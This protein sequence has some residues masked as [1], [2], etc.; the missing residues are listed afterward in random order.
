MLG[1]LGEAG[2]LLP[3]SAGKALVFANTRRKC[4]Q[5][6]CS[7]HRAGVPCSSIHG[8]KD[9]RQR[10]EALAGLRSGRIKVLVA[11]DV[12]ARGLDIKGVGL[13]VNYDAA[14][15]TEDYVHRIGRT[16]RAGAT[17]Y[18]VTFLTNKDAHKARGMIEVMRRTKQDIPR[19]LLGIANSGWGSDRRERRDGGRGGGG[20]YGGGGGGGGGGYARGVGYAGGGGG[21]GG[22]GGGYSGGDANSIPVGG[23]YGARD[24]SRSPRGVAQDQQPVAKSGEAPGTRFWESHWQWNEPT[25]GSSA[26]PKA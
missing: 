7:I 17:G 4:E 26:A 5:L 22:G 3:T 21:Y 15:N 24:R 9:Q 25:A 16:G 20:D 8:D 18:A 19:G 11:T 13:V 14:N 12:A 10:D 2:L 23:G 1:L 6:S